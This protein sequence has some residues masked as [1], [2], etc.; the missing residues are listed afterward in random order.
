M[1]LSGG[2]GGGSDLRRWEKKLR[3]E[4]LG[5]NRDGPSQPARKERKEA[6]TR[7]GV[8]GG[9]REKEGH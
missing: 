6:R 5:E 7:D 2:G 8:P 9:G 3:R 4:T 1:V